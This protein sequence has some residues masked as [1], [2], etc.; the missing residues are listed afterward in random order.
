[1]GDN[2]SLVQISKI[3]SFQTCSPFWTFCMDQFIQRPAMPYDK[4]LVTM[5]E[6]G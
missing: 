6:M 5:G 3:G 1:M 2:V 4:M